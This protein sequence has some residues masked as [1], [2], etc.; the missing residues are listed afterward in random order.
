MG[1]AVLLCE[2]LMSG[3][4]DIEAK[5]LVSETLKLKGER[6]TGKKCGAA[7]RDGTQLMQFSAQKYS[8]RLRSLITS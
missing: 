2:E 6:E 7:G 1:R 8:R 3:K 5:K 4:R